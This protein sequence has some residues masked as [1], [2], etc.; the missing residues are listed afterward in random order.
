MISDTTKEMLWGGYVLSIV[1]G[2]V[3]GFVFLLFFWDSRD[4][5]HLVTA[6]SL[7]SY[8]GL[9]LLLSGIFSKFLAPIFKDVFDK[10]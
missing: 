3:G 2:L 6:I 8:T 4:P 10:K 7:F 9:A 5:H 1:G